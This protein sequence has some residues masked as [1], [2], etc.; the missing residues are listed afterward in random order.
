MSGTLNVE[1]A[2]AISAFIQELSIKASGGKPVDEETLALRMLAAEHTSPDYDLS[3]IHSSS[4]RNGPS[5]ASADGDDK[6][7]KLTELMMGDTKSPD[8]QVSSGQVPK[9]QPIVI[10]P[11]YDIGAVQSN[12]ETLM[13]ANSMIQLYSNLMQVQQKPD[14]FNITTEAA[15]AYN[16]Q[17][18]QAYDAMMGPLAG[19]FIFDTGSSQKINNTVPKDQVHDTFL[20]AVFDNFGFD[21]DTKAQLDGQ[22]TTFTSGLSK[23]ASGNANSIDFS[24]RLGLCPRKNVTAD[25]ENPIYVYQPTIFLIRMS[26]DTNSFYQSTGKKSGVD[27]ITLN[28]NLSVTK[29]ALNARKFEQNRPRFDKMF[30]LITNSNLKAYSDLLNKQLKTNEKNPGA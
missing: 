29:C 11:G 21:K 14:G 22:L 4:V 15:E 25:E 20:S 16:F 9:P 19:F 18:K 30:Q 8:E 3:T 26:F 7:A 5:T 12:Y 10:L 24:L 2:A 1:S 13:D 27:M 17:A 6:F 28:F 23:I